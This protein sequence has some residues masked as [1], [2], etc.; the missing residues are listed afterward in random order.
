M[1]TLFELPCDPF[2]D[3]V[4]IASAGKKYLIDLGVFFYRDELHDTGLILDAPLRQEHGFPAW[5]YSAVLSFENLS[6]APWEEATSDVIS[7][8][9]DDRAWLLWSQPKNILAF[10]EYAIRTS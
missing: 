7:K 4:Q 10:D 9:G 8:N 6:I 1:R 3:D 5:V 2:D